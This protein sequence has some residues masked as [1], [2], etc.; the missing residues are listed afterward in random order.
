MFSKISNWIN[1]RWP[2]NAVIRWSLEEEMP[3]GTSYA[4]VFGSAVLL[5][6]LLQLITGFMATALLRSYD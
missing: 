3:G 4:Y 5:I 6:F 1:V 2:L